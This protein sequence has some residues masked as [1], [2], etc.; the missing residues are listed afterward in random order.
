VDWWCADVVTATVGAG[1]GLSYPF[2]AFPASRRCAC[3]KIEGDYQRGSPAD[4]AGDRWQ[5]RGRV[6]LVQ[7]SVSQ[8]PNESTRACCQRAAGKLQ[9][10]KQQ[11]RWHT[12]SC[13]A[14]TRP[15]SLFENVGPRACCGR[16]CNAIICDP[17]CSRLGRHPTRTAARGGAAA[18]LG[19]GGP[20]H[21]RR[22]RHWRPPA[23]AG[24]A[25]RCGRSIGVQTPRRPDSR[26]RVSA[27][28]PRDHAA[29]ALRDRAAAHVRGVR[30][31]CPRPAAHVRRA[32]V[33]QPPGDCTPKQKATR[34]PSTRALSP[35]EETL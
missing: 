32:A 17:G 9:N 30:V 12:P 7:T 25:R 29:D 2:Y 8:A 34:V 10:E 28:V 22:D 21:S 35:N 18:I 27:G 14:G 1:R 24:A 33:F 20:D 3:L 4:P 16:G 13:H 31:P 15:E 11:P 23:T 5:L 19:T 26:H 6:R